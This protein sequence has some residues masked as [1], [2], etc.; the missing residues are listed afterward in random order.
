MK[1]TA[2]QQVVVKT[3]CQI[4]ENYLVNTYVEEPRQKP[5]GMTHYLMSVYRL[6]VSPTGAAS[7]PGNVCRVTRKL[8][9]SHPTYTSSSAFTLIELLVV[10]LIIGILAAVALP[11]YQKAV[12][13][14]RAV[15]M[16]ST[17]NAATKALELYALNNPAEDI[18]EFYFTFLT[19]P[20]TNHL[21]ELDI[22]IPISEQ[23]KA[24][25][26][27]AITWETNYGEIVFTTKNNTVDF[28]LDNR[29]GKWQFS[30]CEAYGDSINQVICDYLRQIYP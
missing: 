7:N 12:A 1:N 11:Q 24:D 19:N 15:D 9:G 26:D 2:N 29:N 30:Y 6:G 22:A 18:Y 10:V 20:I 27:I 16:A 5:S 3:G 25:Y 13:K 17:L 23:I 21:N 8:S 14:A 28:A 4:K